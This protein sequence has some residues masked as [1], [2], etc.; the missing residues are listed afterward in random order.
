[1]RGILLKHFLQ[2]LF[3]AFFFGKFHKLEKKKRERERDQYSPISTRGFTVEPV[4]NGPIYSG[5]PVYHVH[6]TTFEN[7]ALYL[8]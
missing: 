1:M 4:Y 8:L 7:R 2:V 5:H 6:R 3:L